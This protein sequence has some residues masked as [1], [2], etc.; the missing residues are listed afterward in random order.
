M[1]GSDIAQR[2]ATRFDYNRN[3]VLP[4]Y[5]N[6]LVGWEA[7]LVVVRDSGWA[8]EIEVKISLAD[9]RAE[10]KNKGL[11]HKILQTGKPKTLYRPIG[12]RAYFVN[13]GLPTDALDEWEEA[14]ASD[15]TD[16][17]SYRGQVHS[18]RDWRNCSPHHC[19]RYWFAMPHELAEKL[20]SEIPPYAGLFSIEPCQWNNGRVREI[21]KAPNLKQSQKVEPGTVSHILKCAY[22]RMWEFEKGYRKPKVAA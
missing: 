11:K 20:K 2:L 18:L 6:G 3:I 7:D 16:K 22:Y 5:A 4:N 15:E 21:I 13:R 17:L 19:R 8:E 1:T 14:L 12:S 9:F 10:F